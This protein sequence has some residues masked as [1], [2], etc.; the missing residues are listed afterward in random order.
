[1]AVWHCREK[2]IAYG[3]KVLLMGIVNVTPDSFSDGGDWLDPATALTHARALEAQGAD[4]LDIGGH[5]TRPGHTPVTD[6]EEWARLKP[7]LSVL[8]KETALPVSVDTYYPYVAAQALRCGA[9]IINDVSGV[10]NP[11]MADVVCRYGAGWVIMHAGPGTP[12]DVKAFFTDS[13]TACRALGVQ[14][15]QICLDMGIGFGKNFQQDLA[16]IANI[17]QYKMAGFPLLLGLADKGIGPYNRCG[18]DGRPMVAP[19]F[20]TSSAIESVGAGIARPQRLHKIRGLSFCR[21]MLYNGGST[22][23]EM[24]LLCGQRSRVRQNYSRRRRSFRR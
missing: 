3:S 13:V 23:M 18:G 2:E 21:A 1:M 22:Y 6:K 9:Q 17:P 24:R 7:V 19:T 20:T 11:E 14:D 4:I 12:A 15:S 10:V 8:C 5:S 16:L